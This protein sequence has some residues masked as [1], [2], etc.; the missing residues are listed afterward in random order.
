M[1]RRRS[2]RR[3]RRL[4]RR[5][6][7][8]GGEGGC[9]DRTAAKVADPG[10]AA[11]GPR[12]CLHGGA[13]EHAGSSSQSPSLPK[14]TA[15][16]PSGA[17]ATLLRRPSGTVRLSIAGRRIS[18][19]DNTFSPKLQRSS[20]NYERGGGGGGGGGSKGPIARRSLNQY[21]AGPLGSLAK[22]ASQKEERRDRWTGGLSR[23]WSAASSCRASGRFSDASVDRK[24]RKMKRRRASAALRQR[25]RKTRRRRV[26]PRREEPARRRRR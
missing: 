3:R 17:G 6:P 13:S 15:G 18:R 14:S 9:S 26:G 2:K 24:S 8:S 4:R 22:Q 19:G 10:R 16:S 11:T 20:S 23:S 5:R 12:I 25:K 7:A 1:R 21:G